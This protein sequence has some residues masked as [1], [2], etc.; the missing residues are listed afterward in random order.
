MYLCI[1][2]N[3][4]IMATLKELSEDY[5]V[6]KNDNIKGQYLI[7]NKEKHS[8]KR[9]V[10]LYLCSIEKNGKKFSIVGENNFTSNRDQIK[11]NIEKYVDS[12]EFDS[13]YYNPSYIEGS[14]EE[15]IVHDYLSD[16]TLESSRDIDYFVSK[17]KDIYGGENSFSLS[18]SG[19]SPFHLSETVTL[20]VSSSDGSWIESKCNRDI[21]SILKMIDSVIKPYYLVNASISILRA[22]KLNFQPFDGDKLSLTGLS[23]KYKADMIIELRKLLTELEK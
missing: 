10:Y 7:F 17:Q 5:R 13:E 14:F 15:L 8:G 20:S 22:E 12:L 1:T 16:F 21:H 2:Q 4:Y 11:I 3:K 6:Q 23:K 18:I 19:L 9:Q